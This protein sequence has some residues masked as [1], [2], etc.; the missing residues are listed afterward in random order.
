MC[1]QALNLVFVPAQPAPV[2]QVVLTSRAL[3]MTPAEFDQHVKE[4]GIAGLGIKNLGD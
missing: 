1:Q 4:H 2:H 3:S